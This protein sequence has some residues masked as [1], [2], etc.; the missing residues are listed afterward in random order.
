MGFYQ[1][2]AYRY[3][4]LAVRALKD[5]SKTKQKL[6]REYN[7]RCFL[8]RCRSSNISPTH[9][10]HSTSSIT[11]LLQR[12]DIQSNKDALQFTRLENRILNLEIS[13]CIKVINNLESNLS[14]LKRDIIDFTSEFIFNNFSSKQQVLYNKTFHK[15]KLVNTNKYN[16]LF[17]QELN[18]KLKTKPGWIKNLSNV[19]LPDD[20]SRFLSLGPKF[21]IEPIV[22]KDIPIRDMLADVETIMHSVT[23]AQLR[24]VLVAKSTYII[25]DYVHKNNSKS[26]FNF[27]RAMLH[28]TRK[29]LSEN[30]NI[31]VM[32]SDKC[33]VTVVLEKQ[34]YLDL[35]LQLLNSDNIYERLNRD[36]TNTVQTKCN[37]LIKEL[38]SSGQIDDDT[39]KKLTGYKGVIP[40]FYALPK[41]HKP[42][43]SVR[44]IVAC[45]GSPTNLLASFLTEI[46]TNA[47]VSNEYD[48]KSSF[49]VFNSFNNYQLPEGYVIISLDVVSLFTNV[50]LD[51]ALIA[52]ENNWNFISSHCNISLESFK[53]LISFLFNNTYFTFNNTVFRQ[54]Q[55]TPMGGTISPILACYVMDHLLDMVIPELS[56]YIPFV[57]KYVDD[58][59]LA[60]P[61]N[62]SAEI[63]QVFNSYDPLL[64]FT[65]EHEDDLCS[66]PFLDTRFIRTHNNS[67]RIDWHRKPHSSGRFLNYWSYHRHSIKINLIKQMKARIIAISDPSC[68]QKNLRILSNLFIDNSYPKHLVTKILFSLTPDII[69][70]NDELQITVTS[71]EQNANCLYTSLKY[72]KGITPRLAR[73]FKDIP[74][75]KIAFK[76]SLTSRSIFSKVKDKSDIRDCSNVVY[77][78]PCNNCNLVYVGQTARNLGSRLVSH[79]SDSR[80]YPERSALAEHVNKEHHKMN[81]ESVR[82]LAS[83]S[84]YT[85]RLFLEM[86]FISQNSNAMNKRSDINQL[87]SIYSYL[88]CL[89]NYPHFNDVF[90]TDSL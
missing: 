69:R 34:R 48:V 86:A 54:T 65:I 64:Q 17:N 58:L 2:I 13:N 66:V 73:L 80:L 19:T 50:H 70:H 1:N 78:I 45:I 23:D 46:L 20:I 39:K 62:R 72:V 83:E 10:I 74:N 36:P 71:G 87:S 25:T 8:L 24:D 44:P 57:K 9:I 68:H 32:P 52:V 40:K 12:Q 11:K 35:C 4:D 28:K 81:Y 79:R 67:L 53:K 42:Q 18:L 49:D 6:A 55:G 85:K 3:G 21:S 63:L 88:L 29:F 59:I 7:K 15:T 5:W 90:S 38:C 37:N 26:S 14:K 61:S 43:L 27:Y 82:V 33:N 31:I 89:D 30:T 41:I 75:L 56:F 60:I 51:A 16:R 84:N 76:T 77:Q 22:G 47:Y